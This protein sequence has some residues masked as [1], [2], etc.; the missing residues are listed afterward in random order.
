MFAK[1]TIVAPATPSGESALAVLRISGP[2]AASI[3][4]AMRH[5]RP[6]LPRRAWHADFVA[7]D[8]EVLDDAVFVFFPQPRSHTGDDILEISCHGNPFIV[9]KL[10]ADCVARGCRMAEPGE[11]TRR[12]YL[13]GRLD[14]S[15]AEAVIDVIRARSDSALRN[16]RRQ[17]R[18]ALGS[19]I[20]I[21]VESIVATCA[22]I[23]AY[24]DFPEEDLPAEDRAARSAEI[25]AVLGELRR[26]Q[27]TRRQGEFLRNGVRVV[28]LGEPNAG[29]SSLFNRLA[30]R[31]RAIVSAE[32]GTT[33]DFIEETVR[34]GP[35]GI[36]LVDTAGLR[37][38]CGG[39]EREGVERTLAQAEEADIHLL[40]LDATHPAPAF[41][42]AVRA[43]LGPENTVVALNKIDLSSAKTVVPPVP[44]AVVEVSALCGSGIEAL[45]ATLREL[46]DKM[47]PAAGEG[48][49]VAVNT[50]HAL[51]LG[52]AISALERAESLLDG[53]SSSEL[54]A[55][56]LHTGSISLQSIVGPAADDALLDRL[57][58]SFCIGK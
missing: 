23:E 3:A 10:L 45:K 18:G 25:R 11:F 33:R 8:G 29:K 26:L 52:E 44:A 42:E 53:N 12:A 15:E 40:V 50:R 56:E 7:L 54:I 17:L 32:P 37:E 48:D 51:A 47:A 5:G 55:S 35:H 28:I 58:A 1:D 38:T 21:M 49:E 14:L 6:P 41:P 57:F 2:G 16:A 34:L 36:R 30:G 20:Q 19:R 46:I 43:R 9:S 31:E 39:V 24:I 4:A 22:A 13:N 27:A